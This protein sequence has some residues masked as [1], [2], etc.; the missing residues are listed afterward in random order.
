MPVSTEVGSSIT[1]S[2][3][4]KE[5]ALAISTICFWAIFRSR[6]W[7]RGSIFSPSLPSSAAA[8][9]CIRPKSISPSG[10]RG[11]RHRKMFWATVSSGSRLSSWWIMEMPRRWTSSGVAPRRMGLPLNTTSPASWV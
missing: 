4:L 9:S 5:I 10:P 8:S 3:T 1:S 2:S 6:T 7:R 11:S